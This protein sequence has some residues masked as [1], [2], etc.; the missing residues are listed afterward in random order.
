MPVYTA[1]IEDLK[2][3][4]FGTKN[5]AIGLADDSVQLLKTKHIPDDVWAEVMEVRDEIIGGKIK[6]VAD[7]GCSPGPRA[8]DARSEAPAQ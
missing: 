5:Y 2:A 1:M 6:V 4:T 3:D 7:L 8:D